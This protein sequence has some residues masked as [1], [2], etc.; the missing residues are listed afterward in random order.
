MGATGGNPREDRCAVIDV[1]IIVPVLHSPT[2][3]QTLDA[4]R[5][6]QFDLDRVEVWVRGIFEGLA[7]MDDVDE[8]SFDLDTTTLPEDQTV[9]VEV[10]AYDGSGNMG[11]SSIQIKIDN[12]G[13]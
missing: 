12:V 11:S 13:N 9:T 4:V 6:Q 3:G 10:K 5:K 7:T 2:V 1:S 8:W